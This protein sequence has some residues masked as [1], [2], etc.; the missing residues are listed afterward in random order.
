MIAI[1]AIRLRSSV[2][3]WL[4]LL[5]MILT[6]SVC[7]ASIGKSD[8]TAAYGGLGHVNTGYDGRPLLAFNYDPAA[9]PTVERTAQPSG[10]FGESA[11]FQ[12][13]DSGLSV[14]LSQKGLDLVGNHL[15]QFDEFAPNAQ[16]MQNLQDAFAAGQKV[17]GANATFYLHEASEA[18]FMGN[19]LSYDAA[20]AAAL[21]KYGVSPFS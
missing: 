10:F 15:A 18:T 7:L 9:V 8:W 19:G 21:Q 6:V 2:W 17:T 1:I 12:A 3:L 20:H 4:A 13:A 16:M 5:S 11:E 14:Q